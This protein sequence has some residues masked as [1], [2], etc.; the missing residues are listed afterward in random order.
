MC[1]VVFTLFSYTSSRNISDKIILKWM[2]IVFIA[3]FVFGPAVTMFWQHRKKWIFWAEMSALIL[4]HFMVWPRIRWLTEDK[5]WLIPLIGIPE[6]AAVIFALSLSLGPN[7][8]PPS[9]RTA[10]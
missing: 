10:E 6:L 5:W 8:W 1:V 7:T 9:E 2:N 3:V 4:T